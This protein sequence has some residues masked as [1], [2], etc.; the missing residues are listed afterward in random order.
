ME[1]TKEFRD[2]IQ[3]NMF[4]SIYKHNSNLSN[5]ERFIR[6]IVLSSDESVDAAINNNPGAVWEYH[7]CQCEIEAHSMNKK[8]EI[9]EKE[10]NTHFRML[11]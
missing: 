6:A 3:K 10:R 5:E 4:T 1:I 11:D 9:K 2:C 7:L 8:Y